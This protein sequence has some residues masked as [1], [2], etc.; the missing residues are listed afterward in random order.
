MINRDICGYCFKEVCSIGI[1]KNYDE[2][3]YTKPICEECMQVAICYLEERLKQ[4]NVVLQQNDFGDLDLKPFTRNRLIEADFCSIEK[5]I[6]AKSYEI[7]GIP[8]FG[9]ESQ[10]DLKIALEEKGYECPYRL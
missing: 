4:E 9:K 2:N 5:I 10:R 6:N 8:G 1:W 3:V 7:I